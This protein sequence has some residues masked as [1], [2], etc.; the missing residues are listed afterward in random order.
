VQWGV[1]W[2]VMG[3]RLGMALGVMEC[4]VGRVKL[5]IGVIAINHA[6]SNRN[7]VSIPDGSRADITKSVTFHPIFIDLLQEV[8]FC[9]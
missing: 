6:P 7:P 3:C 4:E 2:D 5:L 1:A 9:L 8:Q